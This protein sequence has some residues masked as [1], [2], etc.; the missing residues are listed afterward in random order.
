MAEVTGEPGD[1]QAEFI[2]FVVTPSWFE[3]DD[4]VLVIEAPRNGRPPAEAG[5]SWLTVEEG[6]VK[7]C[8]LVDAQ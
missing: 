8:E 6:P 3:S 2:A 7:S 4:R 5:G 1:A